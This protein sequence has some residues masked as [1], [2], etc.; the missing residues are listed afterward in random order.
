MTYYKYDDYIINAKARFDKNY[1]QTEGCWVYQTGLN[2][3]G[4]GHFSI[5]I[6]GKE[7]VLRAHRLAWIL[8]NKTD[9][10]IDKPVARHMCNNRSCVNPLHIIPGTQKENVQDSIINNTH[11]KLTGWQKGKKRPTLKCPHC[12]KVTVVAN[13]NRWHFDNCKSQELNKYKL[14]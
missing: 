9:W 1:I 8:F 2:N 11:Y 14:D 4:Y 12:Q 3:E 7:Y 10:P 5:S 13:A 6:K